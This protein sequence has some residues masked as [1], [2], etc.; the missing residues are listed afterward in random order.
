MTFHDALD[1]SMALLMEAYR[2]MGLKFEEAWDELNNRLYG[3][4]GAKAGRP[5]KPRQPTPADNQASMA[6]LMSQIADSDF[7]GARR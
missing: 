1:I 2:E 4:A 7:K 5:S 6:M 3:A